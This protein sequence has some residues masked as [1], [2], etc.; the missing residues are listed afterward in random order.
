MPQEKFRP[1]SGQTMSHNPQISPPIHREMCGS[2]NDRLPLLVYSLRFIL[3]QISTV[4]K[5]KIPVTGYFSM[6]R[7]VCQ[8]LFS[9]SAF[10]CFALL[11]GIFCPQAFETYA[12]AVCFF[13]MFLFWSTD[14][15]TVLSTNFF[16]VLSADL[17]IRRLVDSH[18]YCTI[19]VQHCLDK[20]GI[21]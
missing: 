13:L 2:E 3:P 16:A 15:F 14:S 5:P 20:S 19:F 1:E 4:V 9:A 21:L 18:F 6:C 10:P 7:T 12:C 17:L 8:G 11:V